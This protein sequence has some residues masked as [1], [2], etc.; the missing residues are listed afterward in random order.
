MNTVTGKPPQGENNPASLLSGP[1]NITLNSAPAAN[2]KALQTAR[3]DLTFLAL[4]KPG[5][6]GESAKVSVTVPG[7]PI[8]SQAAQAIPQ[9]PAGLSPASPE[10][11]I[12][13]AAKSAAAGASTLKFHEN[14]AAQAQT[15]SPS[16]PAPVA[17]ISAKTPSQDSSNGSPGD[18]LNSKP[19]GASKAASARTD[20]KGF[21]QSLDT[22]ASNPTGAHPAAADSNAAAAGAAIQPQARNSGM[23]PGAPGGAEPLPAESLPAAPQSGQVVNAARIVEQPGQTEIRIEMQADSLGGVELRAHI[24]GDQI[25]ASISVEHH[26]VQMALAS[27]LP[28]LH[29]ALI[30]KNLRVETLSVSQ[31]T[32]SSLNGGPGQDAGQRG[33]PQYPA[34]LAYVEQPESAQA[35][36]E[37]PAEWDGP[38][39]STAGLSV[40]A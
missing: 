7:Q 25:G 31:G 27:D 5:T 12:H 14:P 24:A 40:V 29:N 21:V 23:Q 3:G 26:D 37:A 9:A 6:A 1:Q 32:F 2:S 30:E 28:A 19:D 16:S 38:A 4:Q 20:E 8:T 22:A 34:K 33:F 10:A 39:N 18:N 11:L 15:A 36:T 17:A 35:F 13:S